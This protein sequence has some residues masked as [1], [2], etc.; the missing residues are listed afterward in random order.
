MYSRQLVKP[1]STPTCYDRVG[2][3]QV[4]PFSVFY[5]DIERW[6]NSKVVPGLLDGTRRIITKRRA[7]TVVALVILK[8]DENERKIC[9]LWVNPDDRKRGIGQQLISE[10]FEWLDCKKPLFTVP[11]EL[12]ADFHGLLGR[13][14]FDLRQIASSYYRL[15]KREY[16]YN[17]ILTSA[18]ITS[19]LQ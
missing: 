18:S 19:I 14:G 7:D 17:G 10:S 5:P 15:G 9:T 8:K 11:E 2:L 4:S 16:V 3:E 13:N 12:L 1:A 6:T